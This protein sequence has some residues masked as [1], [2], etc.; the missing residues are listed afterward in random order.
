MQETIEAHK[1]TSTYLFTV[2]SYNIYDLHSSMSNTTHKSDILFFIM[3]WNGISVEAG[4]ANN[5]NNSRSISK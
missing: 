4:T 5:R 1:E 2:K 3:G